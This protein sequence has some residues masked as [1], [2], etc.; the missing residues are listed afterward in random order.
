MNVHHLTVYFD[1]TWHERDGKGFCVDIEEPYGHGN[2]GYRFRLPNE[3]GECV[4]QLLAQL[5][6]WG[7]VNS[8]PAHTGYIEVDL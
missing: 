7:E 1:K 8:G 3:A 6:V 4:S 2:M 5:A